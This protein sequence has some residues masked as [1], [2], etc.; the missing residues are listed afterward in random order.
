MALG[1]K[2]NDKPPEGDKRALTDEAFLREVDDAVRA[3]DLDG[4]WKRYG[5]WLVSAIVIGLMAFG[6]Y[7]WWSNQKLAEA[8]KQGETFVQAIDK[9]EAEDEA[10]ALKILN[11]IKN[12]ERP[13]Y[14]AMAEL[15]VANLAM[16]KGETKQALAAYAKVAGDASLPQA[17]RDLALIRQTTAE[18]DTL[19]PQKVIDR[20]KPLARP[21]NAWFG[22]AGE[23]TAIAYLKMGKEDL[24]G[25]IFAQIAKQE[26]L[27][28][29]LR[30]RA[31]Q[32][33]GSLGIDAV[34]LDEK[35]DSASSDKD[36]TAKGKNK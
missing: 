34:Q 7:I 10:G 8:E 13:A 25:P 36:A 6:G 12:S 33:A 21:G 32:M 28:E 9:L 24:A 27:P 23:M 11:E 26:G 5:R 3:D 31:T 30:A 4:F 22:S 18:F 19:A 16:E 29:S 20:L 2:N 35:K 1:P 15:V 14:R 17:F